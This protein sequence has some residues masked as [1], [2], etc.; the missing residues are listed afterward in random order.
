MDRDVR[1][2]IADDHQTERQ[3]IARILDST[4]NVKVVGQVGRVERVLDEVRQTSP[5]V[6]LMDLK[7]ED[8]EE[9]GAGAIAQIKHQY[10]AIKI[11]AISVYDHLIPGALKAGADDTL[12]KGFSREQLLQA[13][14]SE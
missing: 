7:W 14:G 3:G 12:A 4:K 5:N 1:V 9:A 2:L 11:V 10:P 8:D 13:I 6:V